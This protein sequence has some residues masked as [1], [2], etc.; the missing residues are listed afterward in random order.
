MSAPAPRRP[1]LGIAVALTSLVLSLGLAEL[2]LRVFSPRPPSWLAIYRRHPAL[3]FYSLLPDLRATVDTGDA[4]WVVLTDGDGFRVGEA[5]PGP[6]SCTDLW[7]G[8]SFALGHGVNYEQSIVGILAAREPARRQVNSAVPGYGPVQY[9]QT[10]EYL[11]GQGRRF[12]AITVMSYV[13]NDFHDA[14]WDKDVAVRDGVV[15]HR[16]DWKS[17]LKTG[18]HL[19]RL[20]SAVFHRL[21]PPA[22]SPF[23]QV[24]AELADSSEWERDFLS[25]ARKTYDAEMARI[26]ALG[27][28]AGAEVRFVIIPTQA[29]VEVAAAAGDVP[30]AAVRPLLPVLNA[31]ASL[32]AMNAPVFDATPVLAANGAARLFLPYDGHL[33]AD[34]NRVV[35]E[36][37]I[38]T[39][40]LACGRGPASP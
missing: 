24:D 18:S 10:L 20:A 34:G 6:A 25:R 8:D 4:H 23:A 26:L 19:Y 2:A 13:G 31:I 9:R 32:E 12:D 39:W 7:L 21:G 33:T 11:L 16:G 30:G 14:L 27:R 28:E 37:L 35:A 17:Y 36:A 5:K 15:G 29:A 3:P 22:E 1:L 38:A 40:P